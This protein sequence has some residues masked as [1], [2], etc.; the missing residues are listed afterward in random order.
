ML[1]KMIIH[2][3]VAMLLVA[4]ASGVYAAAAGQMPTFHAEHSEHGEDE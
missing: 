3:L 1:G 2:G 4:A